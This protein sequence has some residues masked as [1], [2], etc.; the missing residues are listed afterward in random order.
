M[1]HWMCMRLLTVNKK[2]NPKTGQPSCGYRGS[3]CFVSPVSSS[4][5]FAQ[6]VSALF[7]PQ[8]SVPCAGVPA[9]LQGAPT[10]QPWRYFSRLR[11]GGWSSAARQ[12]WQHGNISNIPWPQLSQRL[13]FPPDMDEK[14]QQPSHNSPSTTWPASGTFTEHWQTT[15][16]A[17]LLLLQ[18]ARAQHQ[19]HANRHVYLQLSQ[20][21]L[22]CC[23]QEFINTG[24]LQPCS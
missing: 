17:S 20:L 5:G 11:S 1:L 18:A 24:I 3:L 12:C 16:S 7:P 2:R 14:W 23:N 6:R 13:P 9:H 4:F 8:R 22:I 21:C 10:T 19:L 15:S